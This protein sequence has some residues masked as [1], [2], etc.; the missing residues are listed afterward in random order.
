VRT[1]QVILVRRDL[2]MSAGKAAAQVGHGAIMFLHDHVRFNR[3][4]SRPQIEWLYG[5]LRGDPAFIHGG[6][7]KVVL[8]VADLKEMLAVAEFGLGCG[9]EV[10]LVHDEGLNCTTVCAIGP[11]EEK[12][13]DPV[14]DHLELY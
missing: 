7:K 8:A 1:K 6:M 14:T 9:L 4:L 10:H 13:I 12:N 2:N 3:P 5:E 11:D